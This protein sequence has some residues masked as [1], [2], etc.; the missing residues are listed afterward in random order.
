VF[1]LSADHYDWVQ[2]RQTPHPG[3]TYQ[4]VLNFDPAR[5]AS[6]PRTFINCTVPPLATIDAVRRRVVD[7]LFWDGLWLPNSQVIEMKTGHDPMISAP[8]A[9]T[10]LLLRCADQR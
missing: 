3:G 7:P 9:L 1:G 8:Q 10:A 2:R 4:H 6:V 5:V